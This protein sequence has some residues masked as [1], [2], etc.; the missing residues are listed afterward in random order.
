MA[1]KYF[2]KFPVIKY[3]GY[4]AVDITEKAVLLNSVY[5]NPNLYYLYDVKQ[6]ER[7]DNIADRYYNDQYMSWILYMS[8]KVIDPYYDWYIDQDTFNAFMVQKYGSINNATNKV[9]FF[10]NNWYA[11][12][13]A[14]SLSTFNS[15]DPSLRKFYYP[16]YNNEYV[17]TNAAYY[18]RKK[19]DWV[20]STNQIVTYAVANGTS[21]STDEI[22]NVKF[23]PSV[24]GNGQVCFANSTY[25]T[26]QHMFG[27]VTGTPSGSSYLYGTE[28]MSNTVFS[29]ATMLANNVPSLETTYWSPVYYYD[30]EFEIN[31]QNKSIRVLNSQYSTQISTQLKQ[32]LK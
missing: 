27:T 19:E 1:E 25:V 16:V 4:P 21:F 26:L 2:A 22:V 23:S 28:S 10:R 18:L 6:Y 7:P 3:N 5:A 12:P 20:I 24:S 13:D 8:N 14:V 9:K 11:N 29:S 17:D 15:L 30:Y 32:I 31:E